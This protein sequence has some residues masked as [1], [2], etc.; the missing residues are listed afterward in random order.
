[1]HM[2]MHMHST[3]MHMYTHMHTHKHIYTQAHAHADRRRYMARNLMTFCTYAAAS[4]P[5]A[6]RPPLSL[7]IRNS[8][9]LDAIA[10]AI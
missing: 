6:S 8:A 4:S 5:E 3:H 2:H 1:M 7:Q 10:A 9:N